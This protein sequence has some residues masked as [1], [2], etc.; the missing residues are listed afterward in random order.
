MSSPADREWG[1]L[2]LAAVV[3]WVWHLWP[4]N[5]KRTAE[6]LKSLEEQADQA[7]ADARKA[8]EVAHLAGERLRQ[9]ERVYQ[10]LSLRELENRG[11]A[12]WPPS[13]LERVLASSLSEILKARQA[14]EE[15]E[16][17]HGADR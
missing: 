7:A 1:H 12:A 10:L 5:N 6:R 15:L 17:E 4:S 13:E 16:R 9:M 2:W 8:R 3:L 14:V 11:P